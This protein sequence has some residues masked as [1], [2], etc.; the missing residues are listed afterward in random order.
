MLKRYVKGQNN[1]WAVR[2]AYA[3]Y[4][5]DRYSVT[6]TKSK[7]RNIGFGADATHCKGENTYNMDLDQSQQYDF[8]FT[9]E[10]S[11]DEQIVKQLQNQFSIKN[12][13]INKLKS[14]SYGIGR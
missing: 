12:K 5:Q 13:L 14:Y 7:V 9:R 2:M 11:P 1:S 8:D 6:P 3:M 10:L 4:K